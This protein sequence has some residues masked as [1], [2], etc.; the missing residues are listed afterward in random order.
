MSK[1][2][3]E[4]FIKKEL[5]GAKKKEA[6]RQQKRKL[7][8]QAR[9]R[10][11]EFRKK[12]AE[13]YQAVG[14]KYGNTPEQRG[15]KATGDRRQ[16]PGVRRE[17]WEEKSNVKSQ[18]SNL[19]P[20]TRATGNDHRVTTEMPLNK[21]IAHAAICSRRDAPEMVKSGKVVVNGEKIIQPGHKV[22]GSSKAK[23]PGKKATKK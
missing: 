1:K 6:V 12:E 23:P 14:T 4:K 18:K 7:K 20:A 5:K 9:Q 16:A 10:G 2:P 13:K 19:E 11:E 15:T 3:F 17:A 21:F 8:E 22:S